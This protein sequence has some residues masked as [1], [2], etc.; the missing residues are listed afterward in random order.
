MD[1]IKTWQNHSGPL[2]DSV[3]GFN[4]IGCRL[5]RFTH[6]IPLPSAEDL[7]R[8]YRDEYYATVRPSHIAEVQQDLDWWNLVYGDRYE[9]LEAYLPANHRRILDVGSG[10]GY[11]LL[12]GKSRGWNGMGL[13]PSTDA[14]SHAAALELEI[15]RGLLDAATVQRLGQFDVVHMSEVLEL[16]P[17][18]A[19]ALR[20]ARNMLHPA[21]LLCAIV[22]NNYNAFQRALRST[23]GLDPWWVQPPVHINYFNFESITALLTRC[24]YEVLHTEAN[25]PMEI[26]LLMGDNYRTDSA[27]GR[28]CHQKRVCFERKLSAAGMSDVKRRLYQALAGCGLGREALI[29]AR[30]AEP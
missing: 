9:L 10:P 5:C 23:C 22:A 16:V 1:T 6:I 21:G 28:K 30:R 24:G 27:L 8:I 3:N 15:V 12:H 4:V 19:A 7:E 11:F 2:L 29:V 26:F 25:F 18:P 20:L 14:A 13:E 17:D